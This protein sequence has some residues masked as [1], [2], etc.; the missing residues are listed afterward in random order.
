M[1]LSHD[2]VKK[3][4]EIVD[5]SE[6]LQEIDLVYGGFRLHVRRGGSGI[7]ASSEERPASLL[8]RASRAP[9]GTSRMTRGRPGSLVLRPSETLTPQPSPVFLTF[10]IRTIMRTL[11][12]R[13]KLECPLLAKYN[14]RL[15]RFNLLF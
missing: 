1:E 6:H 11:L 4:L 15:L 5:A 7:A 13:A 12:M 10:T 2:D 8:G 3:I 9:R 14:V